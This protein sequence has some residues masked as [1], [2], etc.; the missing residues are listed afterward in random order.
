MSPG[1]AVV[2]SL[3]ALPARAGDVAIKTYKRSCELEAGFTKE[4]PCSKLGAACQPEQ[5]RSCIREQLHRSAPQ[6]RRVNV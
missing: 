3:P 5:R 1:L 2:L 6:V 4:F